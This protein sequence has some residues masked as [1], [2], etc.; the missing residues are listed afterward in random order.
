MI[1]YIQYNVVFYSIRILPHHQDTGGFF[2]TVMEKI[3]PL[4][5]ETTLKRNEIEID[6]SVNVV[7]NTEHKRKE[8]K[9][10]FQG[11]K[12]DPF[13]FLTDDDPVWP[14]IR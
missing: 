11:Y 13:V 7:K 8:K 12:E 4:P 10:R 9:R 5:W 2:V 6:E 14:A 1:L 3:K